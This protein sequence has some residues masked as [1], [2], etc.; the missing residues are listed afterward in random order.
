MTTKHSV[1]TH[2]NALVVE[3]PESLSSP[4]NYGWGADVDIKPGKSSWFHIPLSSPQMLNSQPARLV[5]AYLFF[6]AFNCSIRNIH[7]YDGSFKVHSYDNLFL[8]NDHRHNKDPEN[9]FILPQE[10]TVKTGIG[11]SFFCI[12]SIGFD[13]QIPTPRLIIAS[14][15]ADYVTGIDFR[16]E[17]VISAK[18][19]SGIIKG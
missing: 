15:G 17:D 3:S 11:I 16:L 1:W 14:A 19:A 4:G 8:E 12:A 10:H 18:A 2:G 9:T 7:I 13:S 6:N 5:R